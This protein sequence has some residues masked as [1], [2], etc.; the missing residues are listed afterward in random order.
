MVFGT[1]HTG[2]GKY[3]LI[4]Y[5]GESSKELCGTTG[6]LLFSYTDVELK[7]G[8]FYEVLD[9]SGKI[10]IPL[11]MLK[12]YYCQKCLKKARVLATAIKKATS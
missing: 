2:N 9:R 4:P 3:H 10:E 11:W 1:Q 12:C 5:D 7:E 6:T 8:L